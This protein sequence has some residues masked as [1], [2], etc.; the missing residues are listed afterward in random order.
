MLLELMVSQQE[1]RSEL[2]I[3]G[4]AIDALRGFQ[5]NLSVASGVCTAT[6]YEEHYYNVPQHSFRISHC[7]EFRTRRDGVSSD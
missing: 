1:F 4:R 7:A 3:Q 6:V 5:E 2:L